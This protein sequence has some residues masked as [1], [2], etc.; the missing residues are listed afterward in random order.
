MHLQK[1]KEIKSPNI[2]GCNMAVR[3]SVLFEI[4]GFNPDGIGDKRSIWLRGDGECGMENKILTRGLKLF[5]DPQAWLFHRIP[6]SR[7]TPDYFYW[8]LFIQGIDDSYCYVRKVYNRPYFF[9]RVTKQS[10]YSFV[11]ATQK[12]IFSLLL[13]DRKIR[14]RADA[15]YWSGKGQHLLRT[16]LSSKLRKHVLLES[17][18]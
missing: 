12:F 3:K 14:L 16:L 4:G 18:L 9:V 13:Q 10:V 7:L 1:A 6:Q 8:R 2:W 15:Y 5:Y 17:Y 11:K